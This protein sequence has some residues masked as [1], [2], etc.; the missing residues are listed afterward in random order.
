MQT[1]LLWFIEL[2]CF[3]E[4]ISCIFLI[5]FLFSVFCLFSFE[6]LHYYKL[7]IRLT[8]SFLLCTHSYAV[9]RICW[10]ALQFGAFEVCPPSSTEQFLHLVDVRGSSSCCPGWYALLLLDQC[11]KQI[12]LHVTRSSIHASLSW[13]WSSPRI[14]WALSS[15]WMARALGFITEACGCCSS[16]SEKYLVIVIH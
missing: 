10:F 12:Q 7:S 6:L 1:P 11:N 15:S 9:N 2:F 3:I 14:M 5:F 8:K 4:Y 13:P 16:R